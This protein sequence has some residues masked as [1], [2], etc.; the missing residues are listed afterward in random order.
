MP[1]K[2]GAYLGGVRTLSDIKARCVVCEETGCWVWRLSAAG[3]SA[4]VNMP[5][6]GSPPRPYLGRRAALMLR[7]GK[8]LP[9][10]HVASARPECPNKLCCNPDH[11]IALSRQEY[12]RRLAE[13]GRWKGLLTKVMA[14]RKTAQ[15]RAKLTPEQISQIRAAGRDVDA[16]ALADQYGISAGHVMRVM[17]GEVWRSALLPTASVF[18]FAAAQ[19]KRAPASQVSGTGTGTGTG[20]LA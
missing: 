19:P 13:S 10:G 14:N 18:A 1:H 12:G 16:Q 15:M 6:A 20:D 5:F 11:C 3:G 8:R 7:S 4:R 17:R 2:P 9:K